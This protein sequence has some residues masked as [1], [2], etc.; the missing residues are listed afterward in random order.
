MSAREVIL[1]AFSGVRVDE[2]R[3]AKLRATADPALR[4]VIA[5]TPRSGSSH[6]CAVL[7]NTQ[8]M[9][10]PDEA[11]SQ[12]LIPQRLRLV[13][14]R[15]PDEYLQHVLKQTQTQNGLSGLKA[16]WF[17]FKIFS[18]L[19]EEPDTW[20][21]YTF[22]YLTRR[23]L[24]AQAVSLYCATETNVFHT[25]VEHDADAIR[26]LHELPYNYAEILRWYKHI[27]AQEAGWQAY[28]SQHNICPLTLYYED[29]EHDVASV[30]QRIARYLGQPL[31]AQQAASE[32]VFRKIG[33]RRNAEWAGRF[34][35]DL[36]AQKRTPANNGRRA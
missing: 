33:N 20:D 7:K 17:Q 36:D 16:S 29:I 3:Y 6:L 32:T 30:S 9:G 18:D 14:A 5:V 24:A 15:T 2:A 25:N 21:G 34:S 28:F 11:L 35:L 13:P 19:L 26:K 12:H 4:Y 23:N 31:A 10:E 27:A 1:K 22:I 8:Q